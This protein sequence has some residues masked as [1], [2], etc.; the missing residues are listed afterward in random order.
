MLTR[1]FL[2]FL[3]AAAALLTAR[4][5]ASADEVFLRVPLKDLQLTEGALPD[6]DN[7]V[8][9][10]DAVGRFEAFLPHAA[11]AGPGE[12]HYQAGVRNDPAL[13]VGEG[14][15]VF[16]LPAP[17]EVKGRV[18][19]PGGDWSRM[20][21]L[22]FT[23]PASGGSPEAKAEFQRAR[24]QHYDR[25]AV[26]S[27]PGAAWFRH[28]A[29]EARLQLGEPEKPDE[30]IF[31]WQ[32][33]RA[34]E[35]EET[36]GV[37]TG[38]RALSEN[39]QLDRLLPPI[40]KSEAAVDVSALPGITVAAIDW[41]PLVKDLKPALDPL[42]ALIPADQHALFF[43]SFQS[44]IELL[45]EAGAHGTPVLQLLEPRAEDARTR[46]RYERQLALGLTDLG[47]LLG[48]AVVASVAC[49]G[50]D[51]YLRVGS[52]IALFFEARAP[53]VLKGYVETRHAMA[54]K[55]DPAARRS[56]GEAEGLSYTAVVS[57]DRAVSSYLAVAGGTVVVTNS[58][59]QLR[60]V[61]EAARGKTPVLGASDEYRFFRDRYPR[62]AA[63][64][65]AFLILTDATIRRWCS[66]LWRIAGSRRTRLAAALADLEA[67]HLGDLVQGRVKEGPVE[68]AFT[69]P[70]A[71]GF[72]LTR[73]GPVSEAYGSLAFMT[74]IV[75][76]A[77]THV[78]QEEAAAYER[79][80]QAYQ[81][82]WRLYFDPIAVR[83]TVRPDRLGL[84]V[85]VL[86]LIAGTE[87][88]E[89]VDLTR[90]AEIAPRAGDP[91]PE[92][93]LHVAMA[94]DAGSATAKEFGGFA[95]R[96]APGLEA[97]PLA[98]LGSSIA[99]YADEDPAWQDL[100][101]KQEEEPRLFEAGFARLPLAL[102][103]EVQDGFALAGFLAT[104]RG[105]IEQSAPG[106]TAWETITYRD[107]PYVKVSPS[108]RA[109]SEGDVRG[110]V[111]D[112]AVHYAAGGGAL[113]VS[114]RE[115]LIRR[116]LDRQL[117]RRA[118]KAEKEKAGHPGKESKDCEASRK[119]G[120]PAGPF[121]L[122]RHLAARVDRKAIDALEALSRHEYR[123]RNQDR[124]WG[125]LPIL[126]EWKRLFPGMDPV[127]LHERHWG[128]RLV[129]PGGGRYVWNAEWETM[130]STAYGHPAQPKEGPA[131]P[132]S[133]S[134]VTAAGFGLTFEA[135][136]LR[137]RAEIERTP[138]R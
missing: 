61:A 13:V 75:E 24:H 8:R 120:E 52:D 43:P 122:G 59:A 29:D 108:E 87:Y 58:L 50:S 34:S 67:R 46:E 66:P 19:V 18:F 129:C 85:T 103:L 73:N 79:F 41:Q 92:A 138:A 16:A 133:L 116:A 35:L 105:F 42:A 123:R 121:W 109:K 70:G 97:N 53:E 37:F 104:L 30:R 74:P 107:I 40:Q 100:L 57:P 9:N 23:V 31:W 132:P 5:A 83:F 94:F 20:V 89:F 38:G 131:V 118:E 126:N 90:G 119:G 110:A 63:E 136:G 113:V 1:P 4:G 102:H 17:R 32:R 7:S 135:N 45:G 62:G 28:L 84:D 48:P 134:A 137:A 2:L 115:D 91:H 15:L 98:W 127:E 76:L 55:A 99:F 14:A 39:L 33:T 93:L 36:Y 80:R 26:R 106:L 68:S 71:G 82:N 114:L 81:D 11:I 69:V 54:L 51:P 111:R 95:S 56:Q 125:N 60:R 49:T 78:T 77:I 124:S 101:A 21:A 6:W 12:V 117:A 86:P 64:E 27:I 88:R 130:E 112:L 10:H 65:T 22:S 47:R 25:L 72:R 96:M 44:L 3:A 128:T